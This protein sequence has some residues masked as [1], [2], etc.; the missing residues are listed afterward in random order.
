M[1]A[2]HRMTWETRSAHSGSAG[3]PLRARAAVTSRPLGTNRAEGTET[4]IASGARVADGLGRRYPQAPTMVP[5]SGRNRPTTARCGRLTTAQNLQV[6]ETPIVRG[7][8][9]AAVGAGGA[10]R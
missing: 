9:V 3:F 7:L 4:R 1:T 5:S 2:R 6:P 10:T 8:N